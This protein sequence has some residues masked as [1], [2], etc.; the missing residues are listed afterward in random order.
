LTAPQ[1]T[2]KLAES[3]AP[4]DELL[5]FLGDDALLATLLTRRG[6]TTAEAAR[7]YLYP[8]MYPVTPPEELPDLN[9][10]VNCLITAI[11]LHQKIGVW[12]DFDVDGQTSTSILVSAL[13]ELGGDVAFH[14]PVR[15]EE[16]HG[17]KIPYLE[18]FLFEE[19]IALLVTCDTGITAHEAVDFANSKGVDVVITDH[20]ELPEQ[21][22]DALACVNPQRTPDDH[23]LHGMTGVGCAYKVIE[24]LCKIM[25]KPEIAAAQLDLT[26]LGTV[27]DV[28]QLKA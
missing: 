11:N 28:G 3:V 21:L 24:A 17:I 2:W 26:A 27:A 18:K 1:R 12:G 6:I 16:N 14:I 22:P 13:T 19:D 15:A 5:Q 20:H 8:E 9:I 4:S 23:P 7:E 10:A 25:G